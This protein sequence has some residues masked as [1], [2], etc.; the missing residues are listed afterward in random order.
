MYLCIL[1]CCR[2]VN[3]A[4]VE[5]EQNLIAFQ[6]KQKIYYKAYKNIGKAKELLSFPLYAQ[7]FKVGM[8]RVFHICQVSLPNSSDLLCPVCAQ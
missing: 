4:R 7:M 3:C 5:G 8:I 2:F 1:L 6:Y